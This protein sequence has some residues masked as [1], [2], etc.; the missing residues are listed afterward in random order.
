MD[1]AVIRGKQS[2]LLVSFALA[3]HEAWARAR[4]DVRAIAGARYDPAERL[5]EIPRDRYPRVRAWAERHFPPD[6][7]RDFTGWASPGRDEGPGTGAGT[8]HARAGGDPR[9]DKSRSGGPRSGDRR[10]DGYREDRYRQDDC[11]DDRSRDDRSRD[12]RSR[13]DRYRDEGPRTSSRDQ[14]RAHPDQGHPSPGPGTRDTR[15]AGHA[16][17]TRDTRDTRPPPGPGTGTRTG[18][19]ARPPRDAAQTPGPG[20]AWAYLTLGLRPGA[21]DQE[22]HIA[23]RAARAAHLQAGSSDAALGSLEAALQAIADAR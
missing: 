9:D 6:A 11:R 19:D 12:D 13:D 2:L 17:D 23:Y 10:R 8:G 14:G 21:P 5:W 3:G 4:D 18:R 22:V 20:P 15:G 1:G 16:R 7:I